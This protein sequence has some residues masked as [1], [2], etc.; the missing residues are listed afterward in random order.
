MNNDNSFF[1]YNLVNQP[2]LNIPGNEYINAAGA[3]KKDSSRLIIQ[4]LLQKPQGKN[5]SSI[6]SLDQAK[7]FIETVLGGIKETN[8]LEFY[9]AQMLT[10]SNLSASNSSSTDFMTNLASYWA[11]Q[12]QDSFI[13]DVLEETQK[14][15]TARNLFSQ[16]EKI[17]GI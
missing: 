1:K 17:S 15:L 13:E 9:A 7:L 11:L 10:S 14:S 8:Y 5:A 4:S 12:P 6:T 2:T 3:H 16:E